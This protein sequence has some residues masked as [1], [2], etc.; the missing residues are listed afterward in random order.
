MWNIFSEKEGKNRE[1]DPRM[2]RNKTFFFI[3]LAGLAVWIA[4]Y[5]AAV[6]PW[7]LNWGA[8]PEEAAR[9]LPGDERI[10]VSGYQ[11]TRA[12]TIDAPPDAVWPWFAQLGIGRGGFYSYSWLENLFFAGIH[13]ADRIV[14]EWQDRTSGDFV[15]SFQLGADKPGRNGWRFDILEKG[16]AFYLNPGWGPFVLEPRGDSGTRVLVRSRGNTAN[17][18]GKT[19]MGLL[20]DPLHFTMEKRMI[21]EV[22]RLAEQRPAAPGW[23]NTVATAG[24]ALAGLI[25]AGIIVTGRR[26]KLP[27]LGPIVWAALC[28]VLAR[29]PQAALVAFAALSL[30]IAGFR[31]LGRRG[32]AAIAGF[33]IYAYAVLIFAT[34]A[35]LVFGTVFLIAGAVFPFALSRLRMRMKARAV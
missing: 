13:N 21:V 7:F 5:F 22:K 19:L 6:R 30:I 3:A 14:P 10:P 31:T 35:Y 28:L 11:S 23:L 24:F 2:K 26:R 9:V 8:T 34:D 27:L 15:R 12:I 1:K 18:V 29:D 32:W 17:P 20:F 16:R 4:A 33:W 25:A